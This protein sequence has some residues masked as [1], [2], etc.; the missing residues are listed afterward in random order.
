M[1]ITRSLLEMQSE[2]LPRPTQSEA[3]F[4][5]DLRVIQIYI[6]RSFPLGQ[7]CP[8]RTFGGDSDVLYLHYLI[9]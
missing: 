4:K 1:S 3:A 9:W 8:Y 7:R 2:T 5:E 6:K